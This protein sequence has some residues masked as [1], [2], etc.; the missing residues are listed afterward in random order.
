[1][2]KL[3]LTLFFFHMLLSGCSDGN[4]NND[5]PTTETTAVEKDLPVIENED[6]T[7]GLKGID[8][9]GNG[10][11]DDIDRLI[12][13]KYS[14]TSIIKRIAEQHARAIQ[15]SMEATTRDQAIAAGEEIFR[16]GDCAYKY[17]PH[18]NEEDFKFREKMSTEIEALTANTKERLEAYWNGE[19]LSSGMVFRSNKNPICN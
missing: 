6:L 14:A 3:G 10:I 19:S 18:A 11:R 16:A 13:E 2:K 1:M 5:T 9:D 8:A 4:K 17:L 7:P 12:A 15:Q